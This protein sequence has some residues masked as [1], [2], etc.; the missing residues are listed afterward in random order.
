MVS[1]L[2]HY[3]TKE[4]EERSL[5]EE[6]KVEVLNSPPFI[7]GITETRRLNFVKLWNVLLCLLDDLNY[8]AAYEKSSLN[9]VF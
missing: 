4:E 1:R 7:F 3:P 5:E 9:I 6:W 8:Q 2:S